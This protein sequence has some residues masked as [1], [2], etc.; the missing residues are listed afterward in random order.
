[1]DLLHTVH[2]DYPS[3][4]PD[5]FRKHE[6]EITQDAVETIAELKKW[7]ADARHFEEAKARGEDKPITAKRIDAV[8]KMWEEDLRHFEGVKED[9]LRLHRRL[10]RVWADG[11]TTSLPTTNL[12]LPYPPPGDYHCTDPVRGSSLDYRTCRDAAERFKYRFTALDGYTL[13]HRRHFKMATEISCPWI[14]VEYDCKFTLDYRSEDG[15]NPPAN[16]EYVS[17]VGGRLAKKC[18]GPG[19]GGGKVEVGGTQWGE[20]YTLVWQIELAD[21]E[22]DGGSVANETL[23]GFSLGGEVD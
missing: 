12:T 8:I 20:D 16:P 19:A 2:I 6:D 18:T 14:I 23:E 21:G 15:M 10:E 17:W 4:C 3:N 7:I 22:K 1:M 9:L 5:C 13:T 11:F